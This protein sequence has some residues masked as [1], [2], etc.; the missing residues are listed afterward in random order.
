MRIG[1]DFD[2]TIVGYDRLFHRIALEQGVIPAGLPE[3]KLAVRDHLRSIG[4]EPVWT[5]MQGRVYGARMD[6]ATAYPGVHA[7]LRAARGAGWPVAI[8]SHKT[9]HPF[10]GPAY[11]LHTAARG[12][13]ERHLVE[14][15]R[16]LVDPAQV[17]FETT[18]ESKLARIAAWQATHFVDDLPEILRAPGFPPAAR[19]I[20]FDPDGHHIGGENEAGQPLERVDGWVALGRLLGCM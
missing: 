2:N 11:D 12:W 18:K 8:I 3:S 16:P 6:E 1:L 14:D 4:R 13:I 19:P 7:F 5:E 10:I 20:L 9:L 17:F 15:G